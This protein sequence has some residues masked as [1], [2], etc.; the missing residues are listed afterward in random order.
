MLDRR[1][2]ML[3]DKLGPALPGLLVMSL[4]INLL[5]LATPLFVMQVYDRVIFHAGLTTLQALV[6][7]IC[8]VI[9]FDFF[10]RQARSRVLQRV[11]LAVDVD[12]GRALFAKVAGLPLQVLEARPGHT[13]QFLFRDLETVRNTVAGAAIVAIVDLPFIVFFLGLVIWLAPPLAW[14]FAIVAVAFAVLGLWNGLTVGHA[15]RLEREAGM[16]RDRILNEI[17][18]GRAVMKSAAMARPLQ[19]LWE[20]GQA[21]SIASSIR[22][23]RLADSSMNV[24]ASLGVIATIALTSVGAVAI[25]DLEMTVGTLVAANLLAGRLI[26]PLSQLISSWR[27]LAQM[28]DSAGRLAAILA[29]PDDRR[30]DAIDLPRPSGR[31]QLEAVSFA[32]VPEA[33][34]VLG[35]ISLRFGP[36]GLHAI[37][38]PNGSG[39]T[40]LL[41]IA[42]GLY[43]PSKGRV[44]L[45]DGDMSQFSRDQIAR[46]I[47]Y[48]PQDGFLFSGSVRE[49]IA[50]FSGEVADAEI[51]A[52][53]QLAG[54]HAFVADLPDGYD[55][56]VGEG[57]SRFS[58]GQRQRIA[59]A[60]AL[61][62]RPPILLLD[63]PTS[64]LDRE[65]EEEL[66]RQL[67]ELGKST[68][69]IVVTHSPALLQSSD[70]IT[71][72]IK[73]NIALA[74]RSDQV[75]PRL[76]GNNVRQVG[77]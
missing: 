74:G 34:P 6:L 53:A 32:Y 66:R 1:Y 70:S 33:P 14:V 43:R 36:G 51:L 44:L 9:L 22:R 62:G 69:V 60:R 39:K 76:M 16:R 72:L 2:R 46:W 56:Q 73:G 67:V 75:L 52:A 64:N 50:R 61:V 29:E 4:F 26:A 15:T 54:V 71:V 35:N 12:L 48:V 18:L 77:T 63:E 47:G 21:A 8:A 59:I 11:A 5:A 68:T 27:A 28:R 23:G 49:N 55:T 20:D 38:G 7:G 30:A 37:V 45:D 58:T 25:L 42:H 40:T 17:V 41:K 13:W 57:G 19:D 24:G 31:L 65:A 10:L 3:M